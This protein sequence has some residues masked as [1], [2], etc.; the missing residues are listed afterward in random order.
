[1]NI[2]LHSNCAFIFEFKEDEDCRKIVELGSFYISK[3][4][5]T[6]RP[7]SSLIESTIASIRTIPIWVLIYNVPLHMWDNEGLS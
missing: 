2:K 1:M 3:C 5:F 7:W 4:L 6:V